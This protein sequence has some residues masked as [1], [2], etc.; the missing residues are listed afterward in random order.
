MFGITE[1]I[2]NVLS[3]RAVPPCFPGGGPIPVFVLRVGDVGIASGGV[4][5]A[6]C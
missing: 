6:A 3:M 2:G 5:I 4:S 1:L